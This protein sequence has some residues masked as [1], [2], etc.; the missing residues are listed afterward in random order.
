MLVSSAGT[1]DILK[2]D[3]ATGAYQGVLCN[4]GVRGFTNPRKIEVGPDNKLYVMVNQ[5][6][7]RYNPVS[8][9]YIDQLY[10]GALSSHAMAIAPDGRVFVAGTIAQ[11]SVDK[12]DPGT[13]VRTLF[14]FASGDGLVQGITMGYLGDVYAYDDI[15]GANRIRR[16]DINTGANIV[17][18]GSTLNWHSGC[19]NSWSSDLTYANGYTYWENQVNCVDQSVRRTPEPLPLV[20]TDELVENHIGT[21]NDRLAALETGPDD[22]VYWTYN[23]PG[24]LVGIKKYDTTTAGIS[25]VVIAG[26]ELVSPQGIVWLTYYHPG[27]ANKDGLVDLQDFGL[28]KDNF[29]ITEGAT[30]DQGDFTGDGMID[31]QDFGVLKDHFGHTTGDNPV[32]AVPEPAALALLALGTLAIRRGR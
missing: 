27:D 26:G 21:I 2:Y 14:G 13:G 11:A 25:T 8:G 30:W 5:G 17:N 29:G 9:A 16:Y 32:A 12:I 28:L 18:V 10:A 31:L 23:E 7:A 4:V 24:T 15:S 3:A 22:N 6:I 20:V 1:N 19:N